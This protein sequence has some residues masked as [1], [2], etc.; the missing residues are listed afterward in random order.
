MPAPSTFMGHEA[1]SLCLEGRVDSPTAPRVSA[2]VVATYRTKSEV[3]M[4]PFQDEM[5]S[6]VV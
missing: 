2:A 4:I 6:Q 1:S 5:P 3:E